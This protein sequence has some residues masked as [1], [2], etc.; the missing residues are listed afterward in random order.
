L[1]DIYPTLCDLTD[2]STP[3]SVEGKSLAPVLHDPGA[4]VRDMLHF[5]YIHYQRA[6]QDD[7]W[8]LIEY[9]VNKQRTTQLFDRQS[10]PLETKNRADD[11]S[12]AGHLKRLRKELRKWKDELGD[13]HEG[14][15][16]AP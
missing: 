13:P 9:Y 3:H 5:A 4:S 10:D 16:E 8:K 15:Y 7:R 1:L 12:C 2:L 6:V 14:F 11:P